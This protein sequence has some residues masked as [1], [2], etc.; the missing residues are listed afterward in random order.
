MM[1][2]LF[3]VLC[4]TL[5]AALCFCAFPASVYAEYDGFHIILES[6]GKFSLGKA[7]FV[8]RGAVYRYSPV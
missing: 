3:K 5:A 6:D 2:N 8:T 4:C 7:T 1:K